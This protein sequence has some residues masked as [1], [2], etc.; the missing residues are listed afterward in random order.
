MHKE[1][2]N[3]AEERHFD[4]YIEYYGDQD[5]RYAEDA[6]FYSQAKGEN[7]FSRFI[8]LY[9]KHKQLFSHYE[10]IW[11]CDDDI[12][13][14]QDTIHKM[15]RLF[16][17]FH[18]WL[19]QPAITEDSYY[20]HW[21]T[22]RN[23]NYVL[24]YTNFVEVM[25]PIFSQYA[26]QK[27]M[28]TFKV[29]AYTWG[30]DFVWGKLLGYPGDKIAII[31]DTVVKHT[32][33]IGSGDLYHNK[34][35]DPYA[36]M[37]KICERFGVDLQQFMMSNLGGV[38]RTNKIVSI[39]MVKNEADIIE[40]F[41]RY[42]LQV[43]DH[44]TI[45]DNDSLDGTYEILEQLRDEGL[46]ITVKRNN[47]SYAGFPQPQ[48]MTKL[49]REV[50]TDHQ[51]D[52]IVPLDADEF[53]V[54]TEGGNPRKTLEGLPLN[55]ISL[56]KWRTYIPHRDNKDSSNVQFMPR[57]MKYAR[58]D[59]YETF[60][61]VIV[62][63]SLVFSNEIT[64]NIGNHSINA[65]GPLEHKE[66]EDLRLAHYPIRSLEQMKSKVI[67]GWI[68]H[69]SRPDKKKGENWHWEDMYENLLSGEI[70]SN[71]DLI[72]LA[73][74]YSTYYQWKGETPKYVK[75]LFHPS[76]SRLSLLYTPKESD[77]ALRNLARVAEKL[78]VV[79]A[80]AVSNSPS[81]YSFNEKACYQ[82]INH[83]SGK[84]LDVSGA[85][86]VAGS[87]VIQMSRNGLANQQW[88]FEEVDPG[89]YRIVNINSGKWL[90][91]PN[92]SII[93]GASM[94]QWAPFDHLS[95]HW[96]M[97]DMGA[98]CYILVNRFSGLV[99]DL[100]DGSVLDGAPIIQSQERGRTS[101]MW[102]IIEL[103]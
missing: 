23:E 51:V 33:P 103:Y 55:R 27:L 3:P 91:P 15:F 64:L 22:I 69:L 89:F 16:S 92:N 60:Y 65:S 97:K 50:A 53:L 80:V 79:S 2:L 85:S 34:S 94:I 76:I 13:T 29:T 26:L 77:R 61:K 95:S 28:H 49:L 30:I 35:G 24:R 70:D 57:R 12:R 99:L 46:P 32:R 72:Q 31:D 36:E 74:K 78:A 11:L 96:M 88:R 62:P 84:G 68:T 52:L 37:V 101:Q 93:E 10:A 7:K 6:D 63:R 81:A 45:L 90:A 71:E 48:M 14:N 54:T 19:A 83:H 43:V 102:K 42:H 66:A 41:V 86:I 9:H 44:M 1:W 8:E 40:S 18:L 4:L 21:I 38:A 67:V 17:D 87:P 56:V 100:L 58:L 25:A 5:R 75:R 20:S 98:G 39:S 73:L 82:I 47:S 59:E